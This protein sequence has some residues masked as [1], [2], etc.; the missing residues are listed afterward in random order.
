VST[1]A[2]PATAVVSPHVAKTDLKHGGLGW[3]LE[4][5]TEVAADVNEFLTVDDEGVSSQQRPREQT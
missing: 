5:P 4:Y 2:D 3:R 1:T